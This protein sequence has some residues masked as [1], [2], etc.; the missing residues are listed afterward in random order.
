MFRKLLQEKVMKIWICSKLTV[1]GPSEELR[2][3]VKFAEGPDIATWKDHGEPKPYP[4][5]G[6]TLLSLPKLVP[7]GEAAAVLRFHD[8]NEQYDKERAIEVAD[9]AGWI[10]KLHAGLVQPRDGHEWQLQNWGTSFGVIVEPN[11]RTIKD[12]A[13]SYAFGTTFSIRKALSRF[14]P[15]W[16]ELNFRLE[17]I[18]EDLNFYCET[19]YVSGEVVRDYETSVEPRH[20]RSLSGLSDEDLPAL[21]KFMYV[22]TDEEVSEYL[23]AFAEPRVV[24]APVATGSAMQSKPSSKEPNMFE[25]QVRAIATMMRRLARVNGREIEPNNERYWG[26]CAAQLWLLAQRI[27]EHD[28]RSELRGYAALPGLLHELCGSELHTSKAKNGSAT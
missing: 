10:D 21:L 8:S 2:K 25:E 1:S 13:A 7:P 20:V 28:D 11:Q 9:F 26:Y 22:M 24:P 16:P 4:S 5:A 15:Q 12:G 19:E 14:A 18:S 27:Q 6:H 23:A 3:F 17:S